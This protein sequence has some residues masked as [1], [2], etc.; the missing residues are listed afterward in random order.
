MNNKL[1]SILPGSITVEPVTITIGG[2]D[3]PEEGII[4]GMGEPVAPS[5]RED[6]YRCSLDEVEDWYREQE[7]L[8]IRIPENVIHLPTDAFGRTYEASEGAK[9]H[10]KGKKQKESKKDLIRRILEEAKE[11]ADGEVAAVVNPVFPPKIQESQGFLKEFRLYE[12]LTNKYTFGYYGSEMYVKGADGVYSPVKDQT[13][14]RLL[15][16]TLTREQKVNFKINTSNGVLRWLLASEEIEGK[17]LVFPK[18]KVLLANGC[19]DLLTEKPAEIEE[20]DFF[21]CRINAKY[22]PDRKLSCPYFDAYLETSSGGDKSIK[23]RICAML[24][25]MML[26]GYPGKKILVLGTAKN[27]GKSMIIRF[28]QRLVGEE[29]VCAQ[30]P[31]DMSEKHAL[32]EFMGKIANTPMDLPAMRIR[33]SS[34][35][36]MKNLSGG[37]M[38]SVN[39]KG[40]SRR[41]LC[42]YTKQVLGTNSAI[43]L[44][45]FDEA[46]WDRVEIIPY[47]HSIDP[48]DRIDNLEELLFEERDAIVTKCLKAARKLV[49]NG[50]Q[51]PEC[52]AAEEMKDAWIGWQ[53]QAKAFLQNNCVAEKGCF[54][55]SAPLYQAYLQ[56][57]EKNHYPNGTMTAFITFAKK[58]FPSSGNAHPMINGVQRRGLPDVRFLEQT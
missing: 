42:C 20:S 6:E 45:M 38:V 15:L 36:M 18:T 23:K 43:T 32:A 24:G 19:F 31:F 52:K 41:S 57:C 34:A 56:Y 22:L 44:E 40:E 12:L 27:S 1:N 14:D 33:P 9:K 4:S 3:E 37:D 17:H 48:E 55:A 8:T 49:L 11:E 54:T 16:A 35:G 50:Y 39:P 2:Y 28:Y 26:S 53:A 21:V 13:V 58:L 51:F 7:E 47:I 5:A 46:F 10:K 30:T 25:Y 29:L